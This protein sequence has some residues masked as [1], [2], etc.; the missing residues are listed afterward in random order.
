MK[1]VIVLIAFSISLFLIHLDAHAESANPLAS[2]PY[3][4]IGKVQTEAVLTQPQES[5]AESLALAQNNFTL[6]FN[7]LENFSNQASTNF[8]TAGPLDIAQLLVNVWQLVQDNKPVVDV[9]NLSA[10]ALPNIAKNNWVAL[11]GWQPERQLTYHLTVQNGYNMTVIDLTY[12][13]NLLFGG[14]YQG[15]GRYVASAQVLP[16]NVKVLWGFDLDLT[17]SAPTIINIG[18]QAD[19][20]ASIKLDVT[21]QLKSLFKNQTTTATYLLQ[22]DGLMK[23]ASTGKVYYSAMVRE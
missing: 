5:N 20:L 6:Q 21:Y 17:A 10:S 13:V 14:S 22:G 18:T 19:P 11:T 4:Q 15:K 2:D 7:G 16:T 23:N 8:F 9:Q 12:Q 3:Y 1:Q